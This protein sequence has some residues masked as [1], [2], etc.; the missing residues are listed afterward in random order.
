VEVALCELRGSDS[1]VDGRPALGSADFSLSDADAARVEAEACRPP[2]EVGV[3]VTHW[4]ASLLGEHVRAQGIDISDRT[5]GRILR[6]ADLQPHRQKM[7]LT[8]Q[9]EDFRKKRDDVLRVYYE[10]PPDEYIV[11]VDE[12]TGI[13]ALERRH[14]DIPMQPGQPVRREFEY[15]RHGTLCWMGA[16]DVRRGRPFG[17]VSCEHNGDTFVEL[18][19]LIEQVY[20]PGRGHIIMDNLSAHDTPDV[21]DVARRASALDAPLHAQ[22]RIMAQPDRVLVLHPAAPCYRAGLFQV[23]RRPGGPDKCVR[24]LASAHRPAVPLD[25]PPKVVAFLGHSVSLD[26]VSSDAHFPAAPTLYCTHCPFVPSPAER[27]RVCPSP[28]RTPSKLLVQALPRS[29]GEGTYVS[30]VTRRWGLLAKCEPGTKFR[31]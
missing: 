28:L 18:L 8:S 11:S 29:A 4:S 9:D 17:F 6:D 16:F 20:P 2:E 19:D 1:E 30:C 3:P 23:R 24:P 14:P 13:Q 25:V 12:K 10:T 31:Q 22:A 7:Y 5:V 26:L 15:I 27:G 21:N